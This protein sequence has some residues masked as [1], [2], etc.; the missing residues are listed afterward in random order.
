[1]TVNAGDYLLRFS[2][3]VAGRPLGRTIIFLSTTTTASGAFLTGSEASTD[4]SGHS[5]H[6]ELFDL[7][8]EPAWSSAYQSRVGGHD[9]H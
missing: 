6:T 1:M 9:I 2:A 4:S 7:V 5:I 8:V 3:V